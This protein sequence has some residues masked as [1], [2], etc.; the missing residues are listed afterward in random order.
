MRTIYPQPDHVEADLVSLLASRQYCYVDC[1]TVTLLTG[2]VMRW[3]TAQRDVSLH[4]IG[5]DP[6]VRTFQAGGVLVSGLRFTIGIGVEVDEQTITLVYR[7]TDVVPDREASIAQA[8]RRGDFDGATITRDRYFA[9]DWTLRMDWVGGVRLFS[10]SVGALE[11]V[12]RTE[13]KLKVRSDLALLNAPMPRN[14]YGPSCQH[15][16]FDS[17]CKLIKGDFEVNGAAE[18]GTTSTKIKFT[19]AGA[20]TP[21]LSLGTIYIENSDNVM[22]SRTI[23]EAAGDWLYLSYPLDFVPE[24]GTLF[25]AFPGCPRTLTAC[26]GFGNRINFKAFPFVPVA[27]TAY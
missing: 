27:E 8:L 23:R 17:G 18:T 21:P 12:G 10:G 4:P 1:Y 26:D 11:G 2:E 15:I 24:V 7:D 19:G 16:I 13:G 20:E 3:T 25:V 22:F 5:A 6:L 9:Q 14:I